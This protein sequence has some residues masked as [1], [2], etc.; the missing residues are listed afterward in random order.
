MYKVIG[1]DRQ[2]YGPVTAD[3]LRIWLAEG[4][5]NQATLVQP[6]GAADWKPL[7]SF[8]EFGAA[9]QTGTP[10][11]VSMPPAQYEDTGNKLAM[12]GLVLG[13]LSIVGCCIPFAFGILGVVFSVLALSRERPP[14]QPDASHKS[15]ALAGLILSIIGL[16]WHGVLIF[17]I[18]GSGALTRH[19]WRW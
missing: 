15:M 4:R 12:A 16:I 2:I 3:L 10:P 8:P 19:R 6:D 17:G 7:S 11:P 14:G 13:I 5:V 1:S 18:L 9:P